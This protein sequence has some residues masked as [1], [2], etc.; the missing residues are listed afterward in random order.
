MMAVAFPFTAIYHSPNR[1]PRLNVERR[2][3]VLHGAVMSSLDGL[4]RLC[5][6]AKQVSAT[7]ITKDDAREIMVGNDNDRPWSLSDSYWDSALR[8]SECCNEPDLWNFSDASHW[9]LAHQVAWWAQQDGFYPHRSGDPKAWTVL[10]HREVY[11]IHSGSYATACPQGMDL[12]L[13]TVRAQQLL[14]AGPV[15]DPAETPWE[16]Y[17]KELNMLSMI[18]AND[19]GANPKLRWAITGPGYRRVVTTQEAANK[20]SQRFGAA[21]TV[22]WGDWDR[23]YDAAVSSGF[24][25]AAEQTSRTV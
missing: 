25:P 3:V 21:A 23:A 10:G 4:R 20:A 17:E 9:S 5:M 15:P 19:P 11:T 14:A 6:G 8:S 16:Q 22:T 7:T 13:V 18:F 12:N 24:V 2:G 1:S